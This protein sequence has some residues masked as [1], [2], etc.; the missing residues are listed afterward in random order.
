MGHSGTSGMHGAK[1][2]KAGK[3]TSAESKREHATNH[4]LLQHVG[5]GSDKNTAVSTMHRAGKEADSGELMELNKYR[6]ISPATSELP[7]AATTPTELGTPRLAAWA[8][9]AGNQEGRSE[10]RLAS[11]GA[12]LDGLE[13]LLGITVSHIVANCVLAKPDAHIRELSFFT[14]GGEMRDP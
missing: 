7:H 5:P 14:P 4:P 9:T 1:Q 6:R 8:G 2:F 13:A 10:I 11:S 3:M 12:A